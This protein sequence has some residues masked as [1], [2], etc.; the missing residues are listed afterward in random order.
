KMGKC[1]PEKM[2]NMTK[3][4]CA[5]MCKKNGCS[6]ECTQKCLSMYDA[7]GKYIGGGTKTVSMTSSKDLRIELS[8]ENGKTK[9]TVTMTDN[10]KTTK[11]TFEGTDA[12][13]QA[14]IDSLK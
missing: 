9:A 10:G 13:V 14:K 3:D 2:A 8:N 11:Q 4:E 6:E 12:E 7:A 5:A 1:D